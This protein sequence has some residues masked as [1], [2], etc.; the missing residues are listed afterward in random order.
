MPVHEGA[1][2]GEPPAKAAEAESDPEKGAGQPE[3]R[4][5]GQGPV[6][7]GDDTVESVAD[8]LHSLVEARLQGAAEASLD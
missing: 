8:A 2:G 4:V 6:G 5:E 7:E 1:A 3:D